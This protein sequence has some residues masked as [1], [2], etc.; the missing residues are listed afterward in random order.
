MPDVLDDSQFDDWM[1]GTPDQAAAL[2]KPY[3]GEI[4]ACE[5]GAELGNV[6]NSRPELM[7]RVGLL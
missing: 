7:E 4:E 1:R 2:R 3:A 5:V 6:K